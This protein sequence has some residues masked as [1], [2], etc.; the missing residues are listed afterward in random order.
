MMDEKEFCELFTMLKLPLTEAQKQ[1]L[2]FQCD[3]N[4]DGVLTT[5]EF[6]AG[7]KR[8]EQTIAVEFLR[9]QGL[10]ASQILA[11]VLLALTLIGLLFAFI[12]TALGGWV[13]SQDVFGSVTQTALVSGTGKV[14]TSL[15][16]RAAG[17][18]DD[19]FDGV[20]GERHGKLDLTL[21]NFRSI[22]SVCI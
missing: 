11:A 9:T 10:G 16:R 14:V 8:I 1:Q 5:A 20:I 18:T 13:S 21:G 15:R 12:F 2:F 19:D 6:C 4:G 17:E 22:L 7:W 3:T